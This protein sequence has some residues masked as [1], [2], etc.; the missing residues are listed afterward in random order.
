VL[1]SPIEPAANVEDEQEGIDGR[2]AQQP[3]RARN[4]DRATAA[5]RPRPTHPRRDAMTGRGAQPAFGSYR[6]WNGYQNGYQ[7]GY[8]AWGS[9]QGWR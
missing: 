6:P 9:Y 5:K 7:S 2:A 4:L 3:D 8:Q 1:A